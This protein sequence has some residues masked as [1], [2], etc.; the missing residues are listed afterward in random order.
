MLPGPLLFLQHFADQ[1]TQSCK[2]TSLLYLAWFLFTDSLRYEKKSRSSVFGI[3]NIEDREIIRDNSPQGGMAAKKKKLSWLQGEF[4]QLTNRLMDFIVPR[5]VEDGGTSLEFA[6]VEMQKNPL[7]FNSS[8]SSSPLSSPTNSASVA[9]LDPRGTQSKLINVGQKIFS[10]KDVVDA[11]LR[12]VEAN[13]R[14]RD[15]VGWKTS[16]LGHLEEQSR[17]RSR[18]SS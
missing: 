8:G 2:D 16:N 3:F 4:D 6:D 10:G 17:T 1:Y 12:G 9:N 13:S 11:L 14:R 18:R 15:S 7:V 5:A